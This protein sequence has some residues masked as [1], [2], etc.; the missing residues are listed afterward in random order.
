MLPIKYTLDHPHH[1]S[2]TLAA[3]EPFTARGKA[4]KRRRIR[5]PSPVGVVV[6]MQQQL[7]LVVR[8]IKTQHLPIFQFL[9]FIESRGKSIEIM[10]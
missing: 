8:D 6:N 4:S 7:V 5:S 3:S 10:S 2:V 9:E 1:G